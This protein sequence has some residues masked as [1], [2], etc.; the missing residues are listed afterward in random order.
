M[1]LADWSL[2]PLERHFT[3]SLQ[4][5]EPQAP[6]AVLAAA[7]L[8]CQALG[9]GDVCLPLARWAGQ[10]LFVEGGPG[11]QAPA[12]PAWLAALQASPLVAEPGGLPALVEAEA[13]STDLLFAWGRPHPPAPSDD[14]VHV[15]IDDSSLDTIERWPW[16]RALMAEAVTALDH[17]VLERKRPRVVDLGPIAAGVREIANSQDDF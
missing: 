16:P 4:R 5:L 15:D 1:S 11:L 9:D 2:G 13:R 14:I 10:P 17:F 7:A 12:L 8:C 3:E 6:D